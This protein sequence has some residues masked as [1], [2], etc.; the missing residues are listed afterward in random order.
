MILPCGQ[1]FFLSFFLSFFLWFQVE[2][3]FRLHTCEAG[4][5]PLEPRLQP[6]F[7]WIVFELG[8]MLWQD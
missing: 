3:N 2:L 1:F 6:F 4:M 8:F 5:L 7:A